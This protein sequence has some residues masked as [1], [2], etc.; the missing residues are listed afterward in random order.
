[1]PSTSPASAAGAPTWPSVDS[2]AHPD[3]LSA[4]WQRTLMVQADG[5]RDTGSWVLWLQSGALFADLRQPAGRPDMRDAT[6][7]RALSP[8]QMTWLS[9]QDGFAGTLLFDGTFFEWQREIG[10][11]P[12]RP[13]ADSARLF[14][15][16]D[17][18]VEEGRHAP[19][20]EE[21]QRLEE[22]VAADLALRLRGRT[23]GRSALLVRHAQFF[24]FARDR[25]FVP[26]PGG[27]L[28]ALLHDAGTDADRHAL[29]DCELSFGRI[30]Q[31]RWLIERST[32]PY[33][34]GI[35]LAP[36]AN[37]PDRA[38]E[39]AGITADGRAV[40]ETWEVVSS[41]PSC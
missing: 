12:T 23:D 17:T 22:T 11:Q 34:E 33:R 18:L 2:P 14:F 6:C 25:P 16:G 5:T 8:S 26:P 37:M 10:F 32:L 30:V 27:D 38:W 7:L 28:A 41:R 1:M 39:C 24:M 20:L 31:D 21:W 15:R 29:L 36:V 40:R 9:G 35:D 19:Y 3:A 13:T 4:A